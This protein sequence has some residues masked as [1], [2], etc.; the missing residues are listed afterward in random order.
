MKTKEF[1]DFKSNLQS[2]QVSNNVIM[3]SDI[4]P[5]FMYGPAMN[6]SNT[7]VQIKPASIEVVVSQELPA[8]NYN[9]IYSDNESSNN[10]FNAQQLDKPETNFPQRIFYSQ[11]K[12]N[13]ENVD[14]WQI[15]KP[16]DFVDTNSQYGEI[17]DIY[18]MNDRT[19]V[20]QKNAVGKMSINERSIVKDNNDNDIQLGQGTLLKRIDYLDTKYGMRKDDMCITDS[21][22]RLFWFDYYN[23]CCFNNFLR[24]V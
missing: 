15:F 8:Y 3:E 23:N 7:N 6:N 21:E 20:F 1:N 4:N 16:A 17:T 2:M 22:N 19:Y 5:H 24:N 9:N 13:G 18:T 11:V 10:I 12:T 14:N